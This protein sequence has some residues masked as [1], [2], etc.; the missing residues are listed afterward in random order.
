MPILTSDFRAKHLF[1]NRH[2]S[3]VYRTLF[4]SPKIVYNRQRVPTKDNDFIDLDMATVHSKKAALL[5][6]GLEG[7]SQSKYVISTANYLNRIGMDVIVLNLR[8]C[9]GVP[10]HQFRTYHSGETKDLDFVIRYLIKKHSY[11]HLALI[12]FSMGGNMLLKYLGEQGTKLLQPIKAAV[13]VSSPIDL[14]GSSLELQKTHNRIYI[15]RFLKTLVKKALEK[16][17]RYPGRIIHIDKIKNTQSFYDFDTYFTAPSFGFN[18]AED[19]WEKAS[20]SQWLSSIRLP[21]YFVTA[22][23]DPFLSDSCYPEEIAKNHPFLFLEITGKG[24]HIGYIQNFHKR[25][26]LENKISLFI[27]EWFETTK[28]NEN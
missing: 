7:S 10:N 4:T 24:G 25:D 5:I 3:T 9:S 11:T 2:F 15:K 20:S 21:T 23:D 8:G 1:Q 17:K 16:N 13:A 26:W 28:K 22:K 27:S 18:S 19:Y 6:H 14:K 12:G